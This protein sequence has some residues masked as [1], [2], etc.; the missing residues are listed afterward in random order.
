MSVRVASHQRN[1]LN[2]FQLTCKHICSCVAEPAGLKVTLPQTRSYVPMLVAGKHSCIIPPGMFLCSQREAY[3]NRTVCATF[4]PSVPLC[5]RYIIP[6]FFEVGIQNLVCGCILGWRS[7]AYHFWV[8]VTLISTSDLCFRKIVS[9][10][11]LSYY[12][13]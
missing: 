2:Q 5:L 7:V 3:S 13:R 4:S 9:G 1:Y 10:A 6:K 8:I 11:Y 12:L